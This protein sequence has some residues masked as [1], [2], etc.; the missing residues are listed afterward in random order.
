MAGERRGRF[1]RQKRVAWAATGVALAWWTGAL[2]LWGQ[3]PIGMGGYLLLWSGSPSGPTC[4]R[5]SSV[6]PCRGH[7][8]WF[9]WAAFNLWPM[10]L[11]SY[12]IGTLW[13]V[14]RWL[15]RQVA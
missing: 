11:I 10:F 9:A 15:W 2:V 5:G 1:P 14:A 12:L 8:L 7:S 3:R 13:G 6:S 4:G